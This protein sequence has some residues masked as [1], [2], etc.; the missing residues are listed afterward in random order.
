MST[1]PASKVRLPRKLNEKID[2]RAVYVRDLVNDDLDRI[3]ELIDDYNELEREADEIR[4]RLDGASDRDEIKSLRA[5][6]GE[7]T[8]PD[9]RDDIRELLEGSVKD[10]DERRQLREQVRDIA[11]RQRDMDAEML[12]LYV[13]DENGEPFDRE[14]LDRVPVRVRGSLT[15]QAAKKLNPPDADPTPRRT[16]A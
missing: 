8:D 4:R 6:L 2:D 7:T 12:G 11:R 1:T 10:P 3:E 14:T 9:E 15:S 5:R 16:A 13:E